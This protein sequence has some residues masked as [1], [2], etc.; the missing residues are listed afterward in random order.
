[1]TKYE[2]QRFTADIVA[3]ASNECR[4]TFQV[5]KEGAA[6]KRDANDAQQEIE[7]AHGCGMAYVGSRDQLVAWADVT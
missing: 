4:D 2:L 6:L 7:F 1:M 3:D 5:V